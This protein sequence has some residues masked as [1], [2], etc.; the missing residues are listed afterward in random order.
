MALTESVI[1]AYE[2]VWAIGT[3]KNAAPD[4]VEQMHAFIRSLLPTRT[5]QVLYGGSVN[6]ENAEDLLTKPDIDG[7][8]IGGA[9]LKP[10]VFG[11][12]VKIAENIAAAS[13]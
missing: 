5:M 3:G 4:Y 6:A 12:I 7:F 1:V 11:Q 10:D 8:L 2:P 9:S 13:K